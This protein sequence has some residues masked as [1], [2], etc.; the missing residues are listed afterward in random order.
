MKS[1]LILTMV[2]VLILGISSWA[3]AA[4]TDPLIIENTSANFWVY[5]NFGESGNNQLDLTL[6]KLGS[7]ILPYR[8]DNNSAWNTIGSGLNTIY[9]GTGTANKQLMGFKFTALDG[10]EYNTAS[11]TF[12]SPDTN[13]SDQPLFWNSL[14]FNFDN[15]VFLIGTPGSGDH[16]AAHTSIP[17]AAW[18]LGIGIIGL[19]GM[20]RKKFRK[21]IDCQIINL[22]FKHR[23]R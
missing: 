12:I 1:W 14:Y 5:E 19:I 22:P 3:G 16:V 13:G 6:L 9:N 7:G 4:A 8:N 21:L 10:T 15:L 18:L 11:L 20:K 23:K 2:A 17:A